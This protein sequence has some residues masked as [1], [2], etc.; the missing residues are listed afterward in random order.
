MKKFIALFFLSLLASLFLFRTPLVKLAL[1]ATL[2][3]TLTYDKLEWQGSHILLHGVHFEDP[4][5][6]IHIERAEL[7]F[8]PQFKP[9]YLELHLSIDQPEIV[10][11]SDENSSSV[12]PLFLLQPRRFIGLKLEMNQGCLDL[13]DAA[14]SERYTFAFRSGEQKE[15][16]GSFLLAETP[17]RPP[18]LQIDLQL[19]DGGLSASLTTQ[20]MDASRL[21]QLIDGFYSPLLQ[22]WK[23]Q[24]GVIEMQIGALFSPTFSLRAI[25]GQFSGEGLKI[26]HPTLRSEVEM[27]EFK[28]KLFLPLF[29][30]KQE[31]LFSELIAHFNLKGGRCSRW[32]EDGRYLE[33]IRE[34]EGSATFEPG[35]EPVFH[36]AGTVCE[37]KRN[38]PF[39][40]EGKGEMKE[41]GTFW[42]EVDLSLGENRH[43]HTQLSF[44]HPE[45]SEYILQA[46]VREMSAEQ[47]SI[48]GLE[49]SPFVKEGTLAGKVTARIHGGHFEQLLLEN[50]QIHNLIVTTPKEDFQAKIGLIQAEGELS[51]SSRG[52]EFDHFDLHCNQASLRS[53]KLQLEE[54]ELH[55]SSLGQIIESLLV[56]GDVGGIK[57][58]L[59]LQKMEEP[60]SELVGELDIAG[61]YKI[62]IGCD[63]LLKPFSSFQELASLVHPQQGWLRAPALP[64]SFCTQLLKGT[65]PEVDLQGDVDLLGTFDEKGFELSLQSDLL[66]LRH[67]V[68]NFELAHLGI[69]DPSLLTR[70]GCI[71]LRYTFAKQELL[72]EI[73]VSQGKIWEKQQGVGLYN[74]QGACSFL[75]QF[76]EKNEPSVHLKGAFH[77]GEC[78]LSSSA[79]V[80]DLSFNVEAGSSNQ[81][82][83]FSNGHGT[84]AL[85]NQVALPLT[86]TKFTLQKD[87]K[88]LGEIDLLLFEEKQEAV[89][90]AGKIE[91]AKGG[92]RLFLDPARAH[93]FQ[94]KL[95]RTELLFNQ[96]GKLTALEGAFSISGKELAQQLRLLKKC[97]LIPFEPSHLS[98]DGTLELALHYH[99][100]L[101]FEVEGKR[102]RWKERSFGYVSAKGSKKGEEW[103]LD[104]LRLDDLQ[105][106]GRFLF[107][108]TR[109]SIPMFECKTLTSRVRGEGTYEDEKQLLTANLHEIT[110][111]LSKLDK[112]LST[113]GEI[114]GKG[115]I[116]LDLASLQMQGEAAL[117][118]RLAAPVAL[119]ALSEKNV[120][121]SYHPKTGVKI[122]NLDLFLPD[123][124]I[125]LKAE[126][127]ATTGEMEQGSIQKMRLT[128]TQPLFGSTAWEMKECTLINT[129]KS[130]EMR[131]S[132][133]FQDQPLVLKIGGR[134]AFT[135][136]ATIQISDSLQGEGLKLQGKM[137]E[138]WEWENISGTLAGLK[139][140]LAQSKKHHE[141]LS[142]TVKIDL[143]KLSSFFPKE[144]K[145][146]VSLLNL[147]KGY[148]LVGDFTLP[149]VGKPHFRGK[150]LGHQ[151]EC[152]GFIFETLQAHAELG[153]DHVRLSQFAIQDRGVKGEIKLVKI[154]RQAGTN[155]WL[156][157][158]PLIQLQEVS[159][160]LLCREKTGVGEARPLTI[161]NFSLF[162]LRGSLNDASTLSGRGHLNFTNI[163]KREQSLLDLPIQF[164]KDLGLDPSLLV[165]VYGEIDL[166]LK[167]KRFYVRDLRN[168]H[169]EAKRG[170]FFLADE[171]PSYIDLSG[172]VHVDIKLKQ[173]VTLK[174]IE[175]F[176]LKVRGTLEKPKLSI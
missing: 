106:R 168:A 73:P 115:K 39:V 154:E 101:R 47:L 36:L 123:K 66:T 43:M 130:W 104:Q 23:G 95:S 24:E 90:L 97:G 93:F 25:N 14:N 48:L 122:K 59:I 147:G 75:A 172:N 51:H 169:S 31:R 114:K 1:S 175:P 98:C 11:T 80:S 166:E 46:S 136:R 7:S 143:R 91:E 141:I 16:I 157:D 164:V 17:E 55:L 69:K 121:F 28:G 65:Y 145:E 30:S 56:K 126:Q 83:S 118:L 139:V 148:E 60:E 86:I 109:L 129:E 74:V 13:C 132:T 94:T 116:S 149:K 63:L 108:K 76:N 20:K 32:M 125:H 135:K 102:V 120:A 62:E 133:S 45:P 22:G 151:F 124:E 37:S 77:G 162:D 150:V 176:T 10:L 67:P 113:K 87:Q 12:F 155:D 40:L 9:L 170:Q 96:N 160:S 119:R 103:T 8:H 112:T 26:F 171:K 44:C 146:L 174:I 79:K 81:V 89:R 88:L 72:A 100:S 19:E 61:Q 52:W 152:L 64:L 27:K 165:P 5:T 82:L 159:P 57:S 161:K 71:A 173:N 70:D 128:S 137:G 33:L 35:N 107:N 29:E 131:C 58:T 156:L 99:D 92:V 15:E 54:A 18:L 105:F 53:K 158:V 163:S 34:T 38:L 2:P 6:K 142:G 138:A 117:E 85:E 41:E 111:D 127:I 84:L 144:G 49:I 21:F 110:C 140:E 4:S 167:G 3:N 42:T 68:V 50:L 134:D 153:F 78:Y